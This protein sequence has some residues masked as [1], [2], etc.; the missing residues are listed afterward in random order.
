MPI[1]ISDRDYADFLRD[2]PGD[3]KQEILMPKKIVAIG[4]IQCSHINRRD[5]IPGSPFL[6]LL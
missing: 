1:G 2:L 6:I 4:Y 3:G 5:K